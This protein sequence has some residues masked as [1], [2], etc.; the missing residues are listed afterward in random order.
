MTGGTTGKPPFWPRSPSAHSIS[1]KSFSELPLEC[2]DIF[3]PG[4]NSG[5]AVQIFMCA[6]ATCARRGSSQDCTS[7]AAV[8]K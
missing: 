3:S 7:R 8:I 6:Q 2:I 4:H 1:G 5:S